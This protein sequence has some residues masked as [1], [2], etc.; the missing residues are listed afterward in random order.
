MMIL[1][2]NQVLKL[3]IYLLLNIF[4]L[5]KKIVPFFYLINKKENKLAKV[6]T[7]VFDLRSNSFM[8]LG[9]YIFFLPSIQSFIDS[10][11]T[12][13]LKVNPSFEKIVEILGFNLINNS[14]D[15]TYDLIISRYE[16]YYK[17]WDKPALLLDISSN[18]TKP[19]CDDMFYSFSRLFN[20]T[21]YATID[22][23]RLVSQSSQEKMFR[24]INS[25]DDILVFN[26]YCLTANYM[27]N[28]HKMNLLLESVRLLVAQFNY[29]VV[30]VGTKED[31]IQ[32]T[33]TYPFAYIDLRGKTTVLELFSLVSLDSV[34]EYVGFDAF[35]M[36][37]FSVFKKPS[38][39]VF[40]G[41]LSLKKHKMLQKFHIQLRQED[42]QIRLLN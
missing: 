24:L 16:L 20:L 8:H 13:Y 2:K 3:A 9:D 39:V 30:L 36:H 17:L 15:V 23:S 34:K 37:L 10:G 31:K 29:T 25:V 32:D 5:R 38:N 7:I 33:N 41:R 11:F 22:Y 21:I 18:L 14:Q 42:N 26:P 1:K 40:R 19:I 27:I 12:V 28:K 35:I 4:F 6:K